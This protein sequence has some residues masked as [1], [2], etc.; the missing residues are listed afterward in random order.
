SGGEQQ[1]VAIARAI[2]KNPRLIL[3]DEP[4]GN[5]DNVTATAIIKLLKELAKDCLIL[6]VSHNTS[7]TY[8]Y[9]DRIIEL[10][11][12]NVIKD[13]SRNAN[14]NDQIQFQDDQLIYPCDKV[15]D[16]GDIQDIN[17]RLDDKQLNK[18]VLAKEKYINTDTTSNVAKRTVH[19]KDKRPTTKS[20]FEMCGT[21]LK[22]KALRIVISSFIVAV[23]I[24]VLAFSQTIIAFDNSRVIET[25]MHKE[26]Q[27]SLFVRKENTEINLFHEYEQY[28]EPL[29]LQ[30]YQQLRAGNP[31]TNVHKVFNSTVPISSSSNSS[32]IKRSNTN[33]MSK[34][35]FVET[36]GTM[37]TDEEFFVSRFG[38][39][40]WAAKLDN[41][42]PR[43][44][45]I[46]DFVADQIL[47][48]VS[49]YRGREYK[50]I[51]GEY[52]I[53]TSGTRA[54]INGIIKTGYQDKYQ[55]ILQ[56]LVTIKNDEL[57]QLRESKEYLDF[58]NDLYDHLG[59][60]YT[61][62][63]NF[64]EDNKANPINAFA[65]TYNIVFEVAGQ[66]IPANFTSNRYVFNCTNPA[67]KSYKYNLTGNEV[68]MNY[69]RYNEIFGTNYTSSTIKQFVPH[70]ITIS[71]HAY[72][73]YELSNPIQTYTF[74]IVKL[75]SH[76]S[77]FVVSD[78]VYRQF[79][80]NSYYLQGI[81]FD[82]MDNISAVIHQCDQYE[83]TY[84]HHLIEGIQTMSRA[85]EVFI[86]IFE[87]VGTI[88]C[89]GVVFL[90]VS[91]ASKMIKD[92][93]HEIGILKAIGCKNGTISMIFGL[94]LA[95]IAI[96]TIVMTVLGYGLFIGAANDILVESLQV[97]ASGRVVLDLEFLTFIPSIA[98]T[99]CALVLV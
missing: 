37:L 51:L 99:N 1:R 66:K 85:V 31:N 73:D 49:K 97:L 24:T 65:W 44:V 54:Y 50:D 14:F 25:E 57:N 82:K 27:N 43:G 11:K 34:S 33:N 26:K 29:D 79:S 60:S 89:I 52:S 4:T 87:L 7:D 84:Q 17:Q 95:L 38:S 9:A 55:E 30:V 61:F 18:V 78:E 81:Y 90:L 93:Y 86:N 21:F 69:T 2:V 13:I 5:L 20:L 80:Q 12:G 64:V 92:K 42:D 75:A 28:Y 76:S 32:G 56:K 48:G 39:L 8:T 46:T 10:A 41:P 22:S 16:D 59:Y 88:L 35:K 98:I 40:E 96:C 74:N 62:N 68:V 3:A 91:F 23:I 19:I 63:A 58:L 77:L 83:M 47:A 94:Q 6:I 67:L 70:T 71:Q 36:Y 45:Y 15:L 53:D 72:Y